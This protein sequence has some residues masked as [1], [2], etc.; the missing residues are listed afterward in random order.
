MSE[1]G[2]QTVIEAVGLAKIYWDGSN[3]LKI[4][5]DISLSVYKGEGIAVIGPSGCGKSTLLN[6]LSGLDRPTEGAVRLLGK[7]LGRLGEAE[8][9]RLRANGVGF[10]FQAYHL[11]PE[12]TALEN[13]MVPL[14]VAG[15]SEPEAAQKAALALAE[16][17]LT[18]RAGHYPSELSGGEQQ[19]AA[20]ARAVV[21]DPE[22]VFCDEPTGN[23]DP[24]TASGISELI[25]RL[26]RQ[27]GR[28]VVIVTHDERLAARA[29]RVW[30]LVG[31]SW[32]PSGTARPK[33]DR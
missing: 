2:R 31:K 14:L 7:E 19:R 18:E 26:Y 32:R 29:T 5:S 17:G 3:S 12:F 30:E 21:N 1:A 23:L 8:K 6:L 13:V 20:I 28:T 24:G 22:I 25:E 15:R 4:L 27:K 11:L 33:E 9:A 16:V 10:V